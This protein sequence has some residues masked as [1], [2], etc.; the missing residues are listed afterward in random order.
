MK[1]ELARAAILAIADAM[2][3]ML[4]EEDGARYIDEDGK[5][6][7]VYCENTWGHFD[8]CPV[9]TNEFIQQYA[10]QIRVEE[11]EA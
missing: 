9:H 11:E 8:N 6:A 2:N 1:D 7:C 4:I 10:E 5:Y 3:K